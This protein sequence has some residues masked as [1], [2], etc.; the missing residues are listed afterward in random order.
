VKY[1]LKTP[2]GVT[3]P[4]PHF[5]AWHFRVL[6]RKVVL[7]GKCLPI[8]W[9]ILFDLGESLADLIRT[10]LAFCRFNQMILCFSGV[11]LGSTSLI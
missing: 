11:R 7:A 4:P 8:L 5:G 3:P 6:F 10:S 2:C 1:L 9:L